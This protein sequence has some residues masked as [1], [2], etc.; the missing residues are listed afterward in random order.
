MLTI[1]IKT[2]KKTSTSAA[3][4]FS[5]PLTLHHQ[6]IKKEDTLMAGLEKL[7]EHSIFCPYGIFE[8]VLIQGL[9]QHKKASIFADKETVPFKKGCCEGYLAVI[10]YYNNSI[11]IFNE[12]SRLGSEKDTDYALLYH[13]KPVYNNL[14]LFKPALLPEIDGKTENITK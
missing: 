5:R 14:L 13:Q 4:D 7:G 12:F 8:K 6:L 3:Y 2:I 11:K 1:E 9:L 10:N